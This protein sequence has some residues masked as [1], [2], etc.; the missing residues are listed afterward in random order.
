MKGISSLQKRAIQLEM[1]SGINV[2]S[3]DESR[4]PS[5]TSTKS[6]CCYVSHK[7]KCKE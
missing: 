1:N 3:S 5:Y 2:G 7:Q 6:W 4:P